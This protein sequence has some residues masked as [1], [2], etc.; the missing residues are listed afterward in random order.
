M[1][2]SSFS[3]FRLDATAQV[4]EQTP[5]EVTEQ[6]PSNAPLNAQE[7]SEEEQLRFAIALSLDLAKGFTN[8]KN[9]SGKKCAPNAPQRKLK[10]IGTF[11]TLYKNKFRRNRIFYLD[12]SE[13]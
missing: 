12:E 6:T 5:A 10:N 9:N 11:C 2:N 4:T 8:Q 13:I 7:M 1:P 3:I